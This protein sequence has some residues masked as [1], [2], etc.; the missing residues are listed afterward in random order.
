MKI[1]VISLAEAVERQAFIA[2][3]MEALGL[4]YSIVQGVRV[5]DDL[6]SK[7][8][9]NDRGRRLRYGYALSKS[10][11][12]C[13]LAHREVW[14]MVDQQKE[15][16][17]IL[18]DDALVSGLSREIL[19]QI[20]EV[21]FPL[22]RL[23]GVFEKRHKFIDRT[24]FAKYWGDPSGTAAYVLGPKQAHRLLEKS[25]RFYTPVDDYMEARHLHGLHTYAFLPYPVRQA[26]FDTQI[27]DR[28]RP[29][30]SGLIRFRLMFV[31]IPIDIK[32]YLK[33]IAY[34]MFPASIF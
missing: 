7:S 15:K 9:Y 10:E 31:R 30:L 17:L 16:C 6:V 12:G 13:F 18:E 3:Q 27:G 5:D 25:K 21:T 14:K 26:G 32:K 19:D 22:V 2:K 8:G 28:S 11:I 20:E 4:T 34:Y 24:P 29:R 23:A 1:F 33:R